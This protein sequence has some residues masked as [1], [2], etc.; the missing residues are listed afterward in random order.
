MD[1]AA[2]T[3]CKLLAAISSCLE[4]EAL[5]QGLAALRATAGYRCPNALAF[6]AHLI[7]ELASERSSMAANVERI[8]FNLEAAADELLQ[9]GRRLRA[10]AKDQPAS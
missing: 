3:P 10:L 9:L 2:S 1:P 8:A 6:A 7:F 4:L 5:C